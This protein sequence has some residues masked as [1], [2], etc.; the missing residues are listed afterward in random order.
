MQ[1]V[2]GGYMSQDAESGRRAAKFGRSVAVRTAEILG[3]RLVKE[4]SSNLVV[5]D[6]QKAV[7]K[8]A[9]KANPS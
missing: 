6:G 5:V 3:A 8:S 1:R 2:S 4:G 7:V 9:H